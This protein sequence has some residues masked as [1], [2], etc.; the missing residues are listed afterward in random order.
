MVAGRSLS[1]IFRPMTAGSL[2]NALVQNRY[3][4][5]AAPSAF[6]PSS[7]EPSSRPLTARRPMTSKYEPPTTPARTERGSPRPSIV[8]SIVEKSP[9]AESDFTPACRS[10]ISGTE[11]FAFSVPRP[12]ALCRM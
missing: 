10:L 9:N 3:V 8:N 1:V 6:G 11:K 7:P 5:T 2:L 4:S 12:G